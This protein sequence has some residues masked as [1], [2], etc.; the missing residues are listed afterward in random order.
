MVANT[1]AMTIQG[2]RKH[3]A[4]LEQIQKVLE[5]EARKGYSDS[6]ATNGVSVFAGERIARVMS[7]LDV[8]SR[9]PVQDLDALLSGY[10]ELEPGSRER[11]VTEALSILRDVLGQSPVP[12][13]KPAPVPSKP[14]A[15]RRERKKQPQPTIGSLSGSVRLLPMVGEGRVKQLEQLGVTTVR[16]LIYLFPRRHIDYGNLEKINSL[17]F[18]QMSTIQGVVQSVSVSPTRTGKKLADVVVADETGWIHAI[19]F[20]P[21]IERQLSEGT[22]VSLSGRVEQMRGTLCLK[23]PE[24]E[25]LSEETIHTGRITP[26]YPLTK[27][28]YQKTLRTLVRAALDRSL[29]L[30][31]E[32]LPDETLERARLIGLRDAI[33]WIH[34]PVGDTSEQ[35]QRRLKEARSRLAFDELLLMQIGLLQQKQEWQAGPGNEIAIDR[36]AVRTFTSSLPFDLTTAQKRALGEI[37]RDMA[38]PLPMTRLLQGDVGSGKTAVA[39]A[40][41]LAV[42]RDG[43]QA[44]IM[45]PTELLAEQHLRSLTGLFSNLPDDLRPT[46]GLIT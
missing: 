2:D 1:S 3:T 5:L 46:I 9:R 45:A 38:S 15:Q 39:A 42:I 7:H 30:I 28:L 23:S 41:A 27:G 16:D 6:S 18:G 12:M 10:G 44:A 33:E 20:N 29:H 11:V 24:W 43:Y 36:D 37:L 22:V 26:V 32:H 31:E 40:A 35:A 8:S 19:F 17:L 4:A 14:P 13:P 25:I 21:Y 34:F